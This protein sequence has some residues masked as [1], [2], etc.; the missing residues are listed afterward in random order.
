MV[1]DI[2]KVAKHLTRENFVDWL[3][4][5]PD[6][7]TFDVDSETDNVLARWAT[8][9]V[10]SVSCCAVPYVMTVGN[11]MYVYYGNRKLFGY[12]MEKW[13]REYALCL[14]RFLRYKSKNTATKHDCLGAMREYDYVQYLK[15]QQRRQA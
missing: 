8:A 5:C 10:R 9:V 1:V 6:T 15:G 13:M 4:C 12:K 14:R 7:I 11:T 3:H 2:I